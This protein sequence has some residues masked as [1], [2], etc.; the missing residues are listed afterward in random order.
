M[1]LLSMRVFAINA[2]KPSPA[3]RV[4]SRPFCTKKVLPT[5][6]PLNKKHLQDTSEI[7]RVYS[8]ETS[9]LASSSSD[10]SKLSLGI[11][12]HLPKL[13]CFG[14]HALQE[15]MPIQKQSL[16]R[17][18]SGKGSQEGIK[19]ARRTLQVTFT[20]NKCGEAPSCAIP[21]SVEG[22][23]TKDSRASNL[24]FS[25]RRADSEACQPFGM[26]EGSSICSVRGVQSM[27]QIARQ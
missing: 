26:G 12:F 19:L 10:Q 24:M 13:Q 11:A 27:A 17:A 9:D 1:P 20:C 15:I 14:N 18:G 5:Q 4:A 21:W 3:A 16:A 23:G 6:P 25:S 8:L 22:N 7:Y 2:K